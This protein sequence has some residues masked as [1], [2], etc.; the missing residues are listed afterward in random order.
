MEI[1]RYDT[2]SHLAHAISYNGLIFISGQVCANLDGDIESQTR[3][4]LHKLEARLQTAGSAK[5][6]LL[7]AQIW[8]KDIKDRDAFNDV[9]IPWI[10]DKVCARACVQAA[11]ADERMLVEVAAVAAAI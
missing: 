9:W 3:E 4:T 11:L 7:F 5:H 8:L 6:R 2:A 10:G 1:L